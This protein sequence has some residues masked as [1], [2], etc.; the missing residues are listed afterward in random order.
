[1]FSWFSTLKQNLNI[2]DTPQ[3]R[4]AKHKNQ[5]I[6]NTYNLLWETV[7]IQKTNSNYEEIAV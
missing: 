4:S 6:I 2:T 1:M 3:T 7:H 5:E